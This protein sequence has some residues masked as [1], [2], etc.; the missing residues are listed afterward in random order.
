M[1]TLD[2]TE[3]N[4]LIFKYQQNGLSFEDAVKKVN[5]FHNSLKKLNRDLKQKGHSDKNIQDTFKKEFWN[6]C[7]KLE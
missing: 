6:L 1:K 3:R 2:K 5:N 7:Q 4:Y